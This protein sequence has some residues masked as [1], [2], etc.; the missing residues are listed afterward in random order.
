MVALQ[1]QAM[2]DG[3][4]VVFWH[5]L[6]DV[7]HCLHQQRAWHW[8]FAHCAMSCTRLLTG[9][10][11]VCEEMTQ[12]RVGD[13]VQVE[14]LGLSAQPHVSDVE[15][16]PDSS[17]V[18]VIIAS[19]GVWDVASPERVVQVSWSMQ[20][21]MLH[22]VWPAVVSQRMLAAAFSILETLLMLLRVSARAAAL[23]L[24]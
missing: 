22:V 1:L 6:S 8:P 3:F 9:L 4:I 12:V 16:V 18:L 20:P 14:D 17:R 2:M 11:G 15:H 23:L 19:D 24:W 5:V 7:L 10:Q 21:A 13:A